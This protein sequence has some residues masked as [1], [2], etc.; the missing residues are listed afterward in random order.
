MPA[1]ASEVN[2]VAVAPRSAKLCSVGGEVGAA[3]VGLRRSS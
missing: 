2:V 3:D 1:L